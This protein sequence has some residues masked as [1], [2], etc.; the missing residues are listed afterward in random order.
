MLIEL[1][2]RRNDRLSKPPTNLWKLRW[3]I[4]TT[5][6]LTINSAWTPETAYPSIKETLREF[7]GRIATLAIDGVHLY[8]GTSLTF[9][10]C[11][12]DALASLSFKGMASVASGRSLTAGIEVEDLEGTRYLVL[13]DGTVY[14]E[15]KELSRVA[16]D[17]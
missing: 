8:D 9:L 14:V 17:N 1:N 5:G 13:R 3:R 10:R 4:I 15:E 11:P 2:A 12:G 7:G 16:N 6:G